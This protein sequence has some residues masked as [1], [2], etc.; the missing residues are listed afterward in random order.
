MRAAAAIATFATQT[1]DAME[2]SWRALIGTRTSE[3]R[4]K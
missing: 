3:R 2:P 4:G 1:A